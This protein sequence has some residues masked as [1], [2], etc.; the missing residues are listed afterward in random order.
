MR[1]VKFSDKELFQG[2]IA[3]DE[4]VLKEYYVLYFQNV[5]RYVLSNSGSEEDARDLFQD[6]LMVLFQKSRNKS[7]V[8]SCSLG[9][10]LYSISRRLWL[11]ELT[12]RRKTSYESLDH[13]DFV[14]LDSDIEVISDRNERMVFYKICFEELSEACRKVL[15]LSAEGCS[16]AEIT[17]LMGYTSEQYTRNRRYRCKQYLIDQVKQ[18]LDLNEVSYG[19]N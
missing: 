7:F 11:K 16:I 2:L 9:T 1:S 12:R 14:D 17:V 4:R 13:E 6:A 5:R 10:F 15:A 18:K 8:L 3:Q 19:N